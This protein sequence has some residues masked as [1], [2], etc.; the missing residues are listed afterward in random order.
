MTRKKRRLENPKDR[1]F[2]FLGHI[3]PPTDPM[4]GGVYVMSNPQRIEAMMI[5]ASTSSYRRE[6]L[7]EMIGASAFRCISPQYQEREFEGDTQDPLILAKRHALGKA[8]VVAQ[9]HS[10]SPVLG[11]DE[12]IQV[13][14]RLIHKVSSLE[15]GVEVLM[16]MSGKT[17]F[18]C[19]GVALLRPCLPAMV[20]VKTTL[21]Q[22]KPLQES[23]VR[24]YVRTYEPYDCVGCFRVKEVPHFFESL[25][26]DPS[27]LQGFPKD[28]VTEMLGL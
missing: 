1:N 21:V 8:L 12:M 6:F 14:D 17:I 2:R 24:D 20:R 9:V 23:M 7:T 28:L 26:E 10:N 5:L 18:V 19:T 13:D 25:P 22:V 16:G 11:F 15:E 4:D 27:N 3:L